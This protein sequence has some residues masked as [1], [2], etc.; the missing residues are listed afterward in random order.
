MDDLIE[1]INELKKSKRYELATPL[2]PLINF[3]K[4]F[5]FLG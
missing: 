1:K 4:I 5:S 3:E 2:N